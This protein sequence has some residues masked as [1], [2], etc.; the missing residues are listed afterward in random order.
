MISAQEL[1]RL[2]RDHAAAL[3]LLCRGRCA[4]PEDCVQEAFIRLA[5][6]AQVP[7]EPIA[8]LAKVSRNLAIDKSRA[9]SRQKRLESDYADQ[10]TRWFMP[11]TDQ[12]QFE[13]I[14]DVQVALKKLDTVTRDVVVAHLWGNMTFRQI[15]E[16]FELSKSSANRMFQQGIQLMRQMMNDDQATDYRQYSQSEFCND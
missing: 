13:R 14:Q 1:A 4:S 16:A 3:E 10:C 9:A 7:V 15:A 11:S 5:Q 2:Y 6:L 8:W 12:T